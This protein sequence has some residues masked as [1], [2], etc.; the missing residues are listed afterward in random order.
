MTSGLAERGKINEGHE[1]IFWDENI[2]L[3]MTIHPIKPAVSCYYDT[4]RCSSFTFIMC[5]FSEVH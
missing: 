4:L 3:E 5:G 1:I 2:I